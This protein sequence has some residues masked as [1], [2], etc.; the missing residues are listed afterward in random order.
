MSAMLMSYIEM[1]STCATMGSAFTKATI[2]E[3]RSNPH[4]VGLTACICT[5]THYMAE[6]TEKAFM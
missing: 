1:H 3:V 4:S 6:N 2:F 5:H